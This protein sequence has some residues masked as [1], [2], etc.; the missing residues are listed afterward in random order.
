MR[1]KR[2]RLAKAD[3]DYIGIG[4]HL[5]VDPL[6]VKLMMNRGLTD[7]AKMKRYL[8]TDG[9][10]PADPFLF[11]DMERLVTT[12]LEK[13][14]A[15]RKIRILGDYD[16]DGVCA[17]YILHQGL[18]RLGF[19]ADVEI[20]DRILDGYGINEELVKL[21]AA[22]GVDAMLT[23]DNGIAAG[24]AIRLGNRLGLT[25]LVT[26]HH[27]IPADENGEQ[28][29]P[30]ASAVINPHRKDC[31]YPFKPI[32]GAMVAWH[33][34][35]ALYLSLR[36]TEPKLREAADL[37]QLWPDLLMFAAL[38]TV[39]DVMKLNGENRSVV[40]A[41]LQ[42]MRTVPQLGL[43]SLLQV[44][45]IEKNSLNV[46]HLGFVIGP[47]LNAGGRLDTAK[48]SLAMLESTVPSKA[49]AAAEALAGL[50][51]ERK[52]MTGKFTDIGLRQAEQSTA[53][54][55]VIYLPDCHESIAGIVAGRIRE[56]TYKPTY[57]VTKSGEGLKG[58]GRS[59]PGYSMFDAL[60]RCD[61]FLQKY[62][63]HP[64]AAGFS[65]PEK[66]L[67]GFRAALEADASGL[68]YDR[69]ETVTV[70]SF[71]P[72]P[73]ITEELIGQLERLEPFGNGNPKPVFGIK[74][75]VC[76][77]ARLVGAAGYLRCQVEDGYGGR[78][79]AICFMEQERLREQICCRYSPEDYERF[80]S[81]R[82][83]LQLHLTVYP[84]L[85]TFRDMTTVQLQITDV[86]A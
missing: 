14:A 30:A 6:L 70:D 29:L 46:Y 18:R 75:A 24:K 80:I 33:V 12:L 67:E 78:C 49:L 71:L 13:R 77:Q 65:L 25:M 85:N 59:V 8:Q 19:S 86:K 68:D 56:Y 36:E 61:R 22:E 84:R 73:Y 32:C 23:C 57:V 76:S 37:P 64:M 10:A 42:L 3:G 28:I 7:A 40:Q 35:R 11:Q 21:A 15:G 45:G 53:D 58:S 2:W 9:F 69:I 27:Q 62:G 43:D 74:R 63:G 81:G 83:R 26:D 47:C 66:E 1:E 51:E 54:V 20:P 38:A 55:L 50:N 52:D 82:L 5:G 79:Q 44:Q 60:C 4:K 16:I 72:I 17:S 41:G 39:G 48:R 34:I 31:R